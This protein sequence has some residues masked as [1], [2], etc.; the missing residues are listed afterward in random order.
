MTS[1][2]LHRTDGRANL[3]ITPASDGGQLRV[4]LEWKGVDRRAPVDG[5]TTSELTLVPSGT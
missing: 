4:K 1:A 3:V 2:V 5:S